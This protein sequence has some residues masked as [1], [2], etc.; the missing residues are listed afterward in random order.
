MTN[1]KLVISLDFEIYWGIRDVVKL[2]DYHEHLMGVHNVIPRL[3][4]VF[5][6]YQINATF[7]SVGFLFFN[8]KILC[9]LVAGVVPDGQLKA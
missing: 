9:F 1:G 3:L 6:R 5:N 7:A 4:S 8:N 2:E